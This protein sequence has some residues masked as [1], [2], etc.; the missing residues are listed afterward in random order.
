MKKLLLPLAA[1]ATVASLSARAD[2]LLTETFTYVDGSLVGAVGSPWTT[3]SGTAGQQN[4]VNGELFIDDNETEDTAAFLSTPVSAGEIFAGFDFRIDSADIPSNATGNYI[5]H[6]IGSNNAF[7][8]RF[9]LLAPLGT[10]PAGSFR[11]GLSN[12][13]GASNV[14]FPDPFTADATYRAVVSY[15]YGTNN[16][17][18]LIGGNSI[19]ATDSFTAPPTIDRWGWR[20]STTHGDAFVDNLT[21]ATTLAEAI[22]EP[23][24]MLC[25]LFGAGI[26]AFQ[27]R[28]R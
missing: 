26:L 6:F 11:I 25:G 5:A 4:V 17:T 13:S 10:D 27:R 20:Q 9:Q 8:G 28:R 12:N 22:P 3:N 2:I 19:T 15:D 7:T 23:S 14:S 18:L 1:A 21:V 16:A 24:T